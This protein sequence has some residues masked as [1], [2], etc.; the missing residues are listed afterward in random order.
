MKLYFYGQLIFPLRLKIK[1]NKFHHPKPIKTLLV[2]LRICKW[3][4]KGSQNLRIPASV[5]TIPEF[6]R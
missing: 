2:T 6:Q 3:P 4:R 5:T 1:Y